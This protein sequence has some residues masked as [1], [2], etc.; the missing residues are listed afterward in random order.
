VSASET[1]KRLQRQSAAEASWAKTTDR[2]ARMAAAHYARQVT[3]FENQVDPERRLAPEV[4]A[5]LVEKARRADALDM[6]RKALAARR[7]K[8]EARKAAQAS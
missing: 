7:A 4:R 1:E 2:A 6:S 3:R 5:Q 8:A